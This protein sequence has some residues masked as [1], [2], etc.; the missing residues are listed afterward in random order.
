MPVSA[1]PMP[2]NSGCGPAG[3]STSAER[4]RRSRAQAAARRGAERPS[5]ARTPSRP[6]RAGR[7][8]PR[9]RTRR[10]AGRRPPRSPARASRARC[11][12]PSPC[13]DRP[14]AAGRGRGGRPLRSAGIALVG[15]EARDLGVPVVVGDARGVGDAAGAPSPGCAAGAAAGSRR[16]SRPAPAAASK[17]GCGRRPARREAAA[18]DQDH[19][20]DGA[21]RLGH[22]E[23]AEEGVGT[24]RARRAPPRRRRPPEHAVA[25]G[26]QADEEGRRR[27]R[28]GRSRTV[29]GSG[30][31]GLPGQSGRRAAQ[32]AGARILSLDRRFGAAISH[33][34]GRSDRRPRHADRRGHRA[35]R[36]GARR[37][38]P[39]LCALHDHAPGAAGRARRAE[40]GAPPHPLR[41]ARPAARPERRL[42]QVRQDRR[43]GDGQLPPAR[44]P[45]D[46]RR[47]G[48]ARAG[49]QRP[50]PAGRRPGQLRQHRR[51]QPGGRSA[52]PR[53]G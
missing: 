43:R 46:L 14:P 33:I 23:Q 42:P 16:P 18:L 13:R 9:R 4:R 32:P 51:R 35:A 12:S 52:T 50:L 27:L 41:H 19:R 49:L 25:A 15:V 8:S 1:S 53:R 37:A 10:S 40:A 22:R 34:Y 47:A 38:L 3:A 44:R 11:R 39:D 24:G 2:R 29:C 17:A 31:R 26:D 6:C 45:G 5:A 36:P 30:Q 48:A 28:H 20:G 21:D 7:R